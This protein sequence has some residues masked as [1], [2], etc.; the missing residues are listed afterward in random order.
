MQNILYCYRGQCDGQYGGQDGHGR[1]LMYAMY[2][3][4]ALTLT[5]MTKVRLHGATHGTTVVLSV[6]TIQQR[7]CDP[8]CHNFDRLSRNNLRPHWQHFSI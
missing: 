8:T 7:V 5:G 2:A 4:I 1:A 3:M 6:A